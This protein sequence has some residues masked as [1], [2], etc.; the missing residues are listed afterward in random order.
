MYRTAFRIGTRVAAAAFSWVVVA[1]SVAQTPVAHWTFD[2]H[3]NDYTQT[4]VSDTQMAGG[5][6]DAVWADTNTD[7]LSYTRGKIGGAVRLGGTA[8][9]FFQITSIPE[10]NN[11]IALPD[12]GDA[13]PGTGITVSAWVSSF[14]TG[15]SYQGVLMTNDAVDRAS[16]A[17]DVDRTARNWGLAYGPGTATFDS[18]VSG[19]GLASPAASVPNFEW[20]HIALVWGADATT[21]SDFFVSRRIYV[22]GVQV[23]FTQD[24]AVAK[25]ITSGSWRIGSEG[26]NRQFVGLLDDLAVYNQALTASQVAAITAAG[27]SGTNASGVATSAVLAGD[28]D[29]INGV[30][31]DDFNIIRDNLT[32]NVTARNLGDLNGDR[33]VNLTDFQEWLDAAPAGLGASALAS[34]SS[35]NVPEPSTSVLLALTLTGGMLRLRRRCKC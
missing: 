13:I 7:G 31:I 3:L 17:P 10:I 33:K 16:T 29:G 9:D 1:V 34:L 15:A 5:T 12:E 30:T 28:V 4:T 24:T 32:K 26:L 8:S 6:S 11:I 19:V 18:R 35:A 20:H 14:G 25:L 21:V 23:G 2:D 27:N 22:D